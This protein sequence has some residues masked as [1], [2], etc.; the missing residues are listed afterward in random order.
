MGLRLKLTLTLLMVCLVFNLAYLKV[1]VCTDF[2]DGFES[3]DFTAWSSTYTESYVQTNRTHTG[4]YA[5]VSWDSGEVR[6]TFTSTNNITVSAWYNFQNFAYSTDGL[7]FSILDVATTEIIV[8]RN[9]SNYYINPYYDYDWYDGGQITTVPLSLNVWYSVQVAYYCSP[10]GSGF[11]TVWLNGVMRGNYTISETVQRNATQIR[12]GLATWEGGGMTEDMVIWYDDVSYSETAFNPASP[13]SIPLTD[14]FESDLSAWTKQTI[15]GYGFQ[16]DLSRFHSGL[17]SIVANNSLGYGMIRYILPEYNKVYVWVWFYIYAESIPSGQYYDVRVLGLWS[18]TTGRGLSIK[19]NTGSGSNSFL[20][21]FNE[22]DGNETNGATTIT[23]NV[24]HEIFLEASFNNAT[25]VNYL[26]L[27][28]VLQASYAYS[29]AGYM[30]DEFTLDQNDATGWN[31]Y[32]DD[33]TLSDTLPTTTQEKQV[34]NE[35]WYTF[36]IG[37]LGFAMWLM[38]FY[39]LNF[40]WQAEEYAK[41]L[42]IFIACLV[43]GF[44]FITVFVGG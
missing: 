17:Q 40:F 14:G 12:I 19:W 28:D 33:L 26:Y 2:S 5:G 29:F 10:L 38:G 27:D 41:A 30:V 42:G 16:T 13:A 24:W 31:W 1:G 6:K 39:F 43:I 22:W 4:T 3:G 36:G 20:S 7:G 25:G 21:L 34:F 44:G 37:L 18:N 23:L 11:T 35:G 32:Y 8:T 15:E 9:G